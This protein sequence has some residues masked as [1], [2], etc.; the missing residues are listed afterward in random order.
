MVPGSNVE[1]QK[2]TLR[3]APKDLDLI[4]MASGF[5]KFLRVVNLVISKHTDIQSIIVK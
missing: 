2:A 5:D 1:A 3:L 4:D